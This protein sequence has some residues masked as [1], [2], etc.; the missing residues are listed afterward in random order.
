[1]FFGWEGNRRSGVALA[2]HHRLCGMSTD[3]LNGL[4]KGDVR[5]TTA[6]LPLPISLMTVLFSPFVTVFRKL[7]RRLKVIRDINKKDGYR[8]L[9][10]RQLG[11][12][13]PGDHRGKCYMD[14]KRIQCLSND[15]QHVPIY[16]QP[17]MR[18]S[19]ISV[20][21]DCGF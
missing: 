16:L 7:Y 13:R 17:F 8:Q 3:R 20:A 15:S 5:S 19:D 1:M 2:M 21:S 10:V 9:N 14:R 11:S 6:S 12:L 4:G 18:Y